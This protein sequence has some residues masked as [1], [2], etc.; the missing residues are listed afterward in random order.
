MN[1]SLLAC[2]KCG[3]VA[4]AGS[5]F[6]EEDGVRLPVSTSSSDGCNC[7]PAA[8]ID[9]DGFCE[10]CGLRP[11]NSQIQGPSVLGSDLAVTSN[12]GRRKSRNED[13]GAIG[14]G[15]VGGVPSRVI[16]V[17]DG[18]STASFSHLLAARVVAVAR[19][20]LL[21]VPS[22]VVDGAVEEAIQKAHDEGCALKLGQE[23]D[24]DP[25]GATFAV[26]LLWGN[27]A[28]IGWI[29]DCRAYHV[30]KAEAVQLTHDDSWAAEAM[31]QGM[32][33][34]QAMAAPNGHAITHCIGPLE[35][36]DQNNLDDPVINPHI[37]NFRSSGQGW[38]VLCSDGLFIHASLDDLVRTARG[39]P[40]DAGAEVLTSALVQLV[41]ERGALDNVT[42]GAARLT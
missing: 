26:A 42:V 33:E 9:G 21:A 17:A 30:T 22:G 36:V 25:A 29:G 18:V 14:R 20:E 6:C 3:T 31:R 8:K 10:H 41:L 16:V 1:V 39:I 27:E 19:D 24:K 2:P 34:E 28:S 13:A 15:L 5:R 32:T 38:L 37:T 23:G 12:V 40:D 4:T 7:G 11:S 35:G